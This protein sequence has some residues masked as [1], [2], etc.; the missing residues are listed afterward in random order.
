MIGTTVSHYRILEQLGGGGMGIVYEAED[1]R[2]G[3]RVALKFLPPEPSR[4][5][6]R[7]ERF[8]REARA[9][10]A[11]EHPNICSI[12]DIGEHDGQQ[13]IVMERLE[14]ATLRHHIASR[15]LDLESMLDLA[16]QITDALDVAH[17]KGIVHR[18]IKP[19]NIFVT[20]RGQ[21]KVLDFG[22][23]KLGPLPAE[24]G[25][26]LAEEPTRAR[27]HDPLSTPGGTMGTVAYMS[28][29][30]ARGEELDSRTDLFSFGIVLYEMITGR[31]PFPG[32][33]DAV[34]F[35]AILNAQPA[36]LDTL[37]PAC[38][39]ELQHIVGK[40]LEKDRSLRYQ[41][42]AE[43]HA[44]LRR[45]RRDTR[46]DG[47]A[48][49]GRYT[50]PAPPLRAGRGRRFVAVGL[51]FGAVAGVTLLIVSSRGVPALTARDSVLLAEFANT[52]GEPVFDGTLRQALAVQL[53]Q[54]PFLHIVSD[55]RVRKVLTLMGRSPDERLTRSVAREACEREDA[56]ALIAGGIASLGSNYVIDLEAVDC[57]TGESLARAQR[58]A[59][60]RERVLRVLSEAAGSF[61]AQLGESL[62]SIQKFDRPLE[63]ATTSSLEALRAYSA[64]QDL[65]VKEGD[66]AA[67]PLYKKAV[68]LD[69]DF[70]LAHG[71]LCAI[72]G[73]IGEQVLAREHARKAFEMKDRVSE[74]E[75]LYLEYHYHEKVTGDLR[76]AIETLEVFRHTYPRDFTPLNNLAVAYSDIGQPE[77]ALA[78]GLEA[79]RLEPNN[80]LP[81][82]NVCSA[83]QKLNRWDEA[84]AACEAAVARK[85]DNEGHHMALFMI[86]FVQQDEAA[87]RRESAWAAGKPAEP[88]L[89]WA[90]AQAAAYKGQ[91]RRS[92]E[93]AREVGDVLSR[94]GLKQAAVHFT[95]WEAGLETHAGNAAGARQAV[96]YA[97]GLGRDPEALADAATIRALAGDP[98]GAQALVDEAARLMPST[99]TLFHSRAL[100]EARA[101]IALAR[102][103]PEDAVEALRPAVPF[104]RGRFR[105]AHIRG[106][107]YLQMGR[108]AEAAAEFQRV[109]DSRGYG[110]L[111]LLYTLAH[112]G[113]GRSAAAAGDRPRAR[114]AYQDLL[115]VWKDADADMPVFK[116][117][118]QEYE[119]LPD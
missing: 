52:T 54:S 27:G 89:R 32:R 1:L 4:D 82:L 67:V 76:K 87:L 53:E 8:K 101:A 23:A 70:A 72:H 112:L 59:G 58:E 11:L 47:T 80:P 14:G 119:R 24:R 16:I 75:R 37:E 94:T 9:A 114:R 69:P 79:L 34:I 78:A 81:Y 86:N 33:T 95:L 106:Q 46:S 35:D 29:E 108:P 118:R 100:P 39:P 98:S 84:E 44:D 56:K 45:L 28:P 21:A 18:D 51:G 73:N 25:G 66:L 110:P 10:S 85:L 38:P 64:A 57:R 68:E 105:I 92:R 26:D 111:D 77:Q 88:I 97:L 113:L 62:A 22:L 96:A 15:Q 20:R 30:Q 2:L 19:A 104:Q 50:P 13:F 107:A 103:S 41:S 36:P 71:R 48:A 99:A 7:V 43:L 117:A 49:A 63:E 74:R 5:P 93:I 55:Q 42:A 12:H 65:R 115:A 6:L 61:R 109:L 31:H 40:C 116:A 83:H 90:E 3:R 17:G 91:L 102:R 60:S